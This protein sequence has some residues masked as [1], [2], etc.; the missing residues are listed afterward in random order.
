[1]FSNYTLHEKEGIGTGPLSPRGKARYN[2]TA[3][4]SQFEGA[5][6]LA[7]KHGLERDT[8]DRFALESHR[9]ASTAI[10]SGA[11]EN[12]IVPIDIGGE[13][14]TVDEGVRFDATL[15]GM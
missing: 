11:F 9:K 4:F 12:E 3:Q 8:L 10:L 5:E 14:H 6:L 7:Q 1:M 13:W 15:E 2:R